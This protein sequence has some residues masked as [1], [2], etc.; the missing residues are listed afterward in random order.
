MKVI[1][2]WLKK[3]I[4][5]QRKHLIEL[6]GQMSDDYESKNQEEKNIEGILL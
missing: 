5:N 4:M 6:L 1:R 3:R 2:I